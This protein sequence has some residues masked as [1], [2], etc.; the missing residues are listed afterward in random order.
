MG[1]IVGSGQDK[2][3]WVRS[4]ITKGK[5]QAANLI[6]NVRASRITCSGMRPEMIQQVVSPEEN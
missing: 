1:D 3:E 2:Q 6:K 4:E 5:N